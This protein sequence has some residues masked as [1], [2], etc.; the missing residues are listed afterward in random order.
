M[1]L[2][3]PHADKRI[4]GNPYCTIFV[5]R[6]N[7]NT[8]EER[9]KREFEIYGT[10]EHVRIVTDRNTKKSKGYAFVE[11]RNERDADCKS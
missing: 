4:E 1:T 7:Y 8:T 2:G 11:F 9:I 10:V 3:N 6:L 5:G